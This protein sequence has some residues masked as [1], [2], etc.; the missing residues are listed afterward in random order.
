MEEE[1]T[2]EA[3]LQ[4]ETAQEAMDQVVEEPLG[5]AAVEEAVGETPTPLISLSKQNPQ[6]HTNTAPQ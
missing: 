2:P 4:L 3:E 6:N 1:Q 5:E